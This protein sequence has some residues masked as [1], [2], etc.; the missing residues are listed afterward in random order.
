MEFVLKGGLK[1][2]NKNL[3]ADLLLFSGYNHV[4]RLRR[5]SPENWDILFPLKYKALMWLF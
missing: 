4:K 3:I 5:I 2:P 1:N